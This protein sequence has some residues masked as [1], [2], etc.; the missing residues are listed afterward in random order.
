MEIKIKTT[1]DAE[2]KSQNRRDRFVRAIAI[3][4]RQF[5]HRQQG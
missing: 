4:L 2:F 5:A 1:Y 3:C